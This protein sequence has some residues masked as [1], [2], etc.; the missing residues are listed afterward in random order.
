MR[1]NAAVDINTDW[2]INGIVK[3][4]HVNALTRSIKYDYVITAQMLEGKTG[5][6]DVDELLGG[7]KINGTTGEVH[8]LINT[9]V[10]DNVE[11]F[12][13]AS[14]VGGPSGTLKVH[15]HT[16]GPFTASVGTSG[17]P[18]I[19]H[20]FHTH[21]PAEAVTFTS[22]PLK[23]H[24]GAFILTEPMELRAGA[25]FIYEMA[26]AEL[27]FLD[28]QHPGTIAKEAWMS[29]AV[30]GGSD[31][32]FRIFDT[33]AKKNKGLQYLRMS[34][35]GEVVAAVD[36]QDLKVGPR[37]GGNSYQEVPYLSFSNFYPT[38]C[39]DMSSVTEI[40]WTT[41]YTANL[42][43]HRIWGGSRDYWDATNPY[44]DLALDTASMAI[45]KV[46]KISIHA[47][48]NPHDAESGAVPPF[49]NVVTATTPLGNANLM[50]GYA[51]GGQVQI[52][53][54]FN[55]LFYPS[56]GYIKS[57]TT[58][59]TVKLQKASG[60]FGGTYPQGVSANDIVMFVTPSGSFERSWIFSSNDEHR[61]YAEN[62]VSEALSAT[63]TCYAN[64]S[65]EIGFNRNDT[66][67][68][69]FTY[70]INVP[71]SGISAV[72]ANGTFT[73]P[74]VK[75]K[76]RIPDSGSTYSWIDSDGFRI[77]MNPQKPGPRFYWPYLLAKGDAGDYGVS[78]LTPKFHPV[79]ME[80]VD[81]SNAGNADPS[82]VGSYS[83]ETPCYEAVVYLC[84]IDDT[85]V[86]VLGY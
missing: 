43:S 62:T 40:D 8:V 23:M 50:G 56:N 39:L 70:T 24:V 85:H 11:L 84:R 35:N 48:R 66:R 29:N 74:E 51:G 69:S 17:I 72:S 52:T 33:I 80:S 60:Y 2:Q 4:N 15:V 34:F 65:M 81:A 28:E 37:A 54:S 41:W 16:I 49:L 1:T 26:L 10:P 68:N 59:A 6:V 58:S 22:L 76:E 86:L 55:S 21:G 20:Y 82:Y 3:P 64:G 38:D 44:T 18:Y 45:G 9:M 32:I 53:G 57:G 71:A 25:S 7:N 61:P 79:H 27:P 30:G 46:Y 67:G 14:S 73:I 12:F 63:I 83:P 77:M 47:A 42:D 75:W 5:T 78:Y 31:G 36:G 19:E 13:P